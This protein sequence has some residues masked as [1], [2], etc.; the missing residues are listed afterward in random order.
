MKIGRYAPSPQ[1]TGVAVALLL[2]AGLVYAAERYTRPMASTA[3][4][5]SEQTAAPSDATSWQAALY[6]SQAAN[7]SSSL[8]APSPSVVSQ[9]LA[10]AQSPN[11]TDTVARSMLINL[12]SAKSQGLGDDIPTQN[13]IISVATA[14][15][16][17]AQKSVT[18][19]SYTDLLIVPANPTALRTYG[20]AVMRALSAHPEASEQ[21]TLLAIDE[22]VEGG[23][24]SK[25]SALA[26]IGVAYEAIA[27][28]L[29]KIPVPQTFAPL[30]L[31]AINDFL[32]I[33]STYENMEAVSSD[34]VRGLSGI[35]AY[36]NLMDQNA[37]VFTNM[38]QE[39]QK[40]GILF[41]KDE[42]GTAWSVLLPASAVTPSP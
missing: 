9:F 41:T 37:I 19:Y 34:S 22:I 25:V 12:S 26:T 23:N 11:L 13:Q 8:S 1:F 33:S 35:Q 17:S 14:Q 30:Q 2:S 38:A 5:A 28:D 31:Q 10:A 42:P 6:A 18:A 20:N 36:E 7:A 40:D 39:L 27:A 15:M 16:A 29:L 24:K 32:A 3:T 4:I 21:A